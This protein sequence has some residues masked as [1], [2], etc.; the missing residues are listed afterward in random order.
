MLFVCKNHST[1]P[2]DIGVGKDVSPSSI[3]VSRNEGMIPS[4][5]LNI[6]VGGVGMSSLHPTRVAL[7]LQQ[8]VR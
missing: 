1:L 4:K 8:A 6:V 5:R 2:Y 3:V 7:T